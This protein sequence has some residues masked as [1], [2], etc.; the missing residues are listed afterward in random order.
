MSIA[1]R[2]DAKPLLESFGLEFNQ[3]LH[4]SL[5]FS[6]KFDVRTKIVVL[7]KRYERFFRSGSIRHK[8]RD[9]NFH[10]KFSM[11]PRMPMQN[12]TGKIHP[13]KM[14]SKRVEAN[15]SRKSSEQIVELWV[16]FIVATW[17]V[18]VGDRRWLPMQFSS[19]ALAVAIGIVIFAS[20]QP[21]YK[22]IWWNMNESPT[23]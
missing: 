4:L 9:W 18:R 2:Y 3:W 6:I 23:E 20:N 12:C 16:L 19:D 10:H 15:V 17:Y 11:L 5:H 22:T 21:A 14:N 8:I 13:I 7:H 1:L